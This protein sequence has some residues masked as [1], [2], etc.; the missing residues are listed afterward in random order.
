MRHSARCGRRRWAGAHH[1][2]VPP[3]CPPHLVPPLG[4][5]PRFT[6]RTAA[7]LLP[8]DRFR[9]ARLEA[10]YQAE[11]RERLATLDSEPAW[12]GPGAGWGVQRGSAGEGR[13]RGIRAASPCDARAAPPPAKLLWLAL[14]PQCDPPSCLP[15][16]GCTTSGGERAATQQGGG[17]QM[18]GI[19]T[20][21]RGRK[22]R[23][24]SGA[25]QALP[26]PL[27]CLLPFTPPLQLCWLRTAGPPAQSHGVA[28]GCRP[29]ARLRVPGRRP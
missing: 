8:V 5:P 6:A 17:E 23:P 1:P 16:C 11:R 3:L 20:D 21:S 10:E 2:L 9:E 26:P 13:R 24:C 4:L 18:P 27:P 28:V 14:P 22:R 19:L 15:C 7:M 29:Q 12:Q 25:P